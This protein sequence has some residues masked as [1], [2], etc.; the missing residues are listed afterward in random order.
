MPNQLYSISTTVIY[1]MFNLVFQ[2]RYIEN[3]MKSAE[4]RKRAEE[5]R[6]ER[7]VQKER[8]EEG[9]MYADKES[10]VTSAYR[11]KMEEMKQAEEEEKR[12][13]QLEGQWSVS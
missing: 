5:R 13:E 10:F 3:L 4:A 9:E 8:E 11:A 2:P 1:Y 6:V 7:K 12:K